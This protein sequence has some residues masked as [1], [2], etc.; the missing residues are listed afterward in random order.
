MSAATAAYE[1]HLQAARVASQRINKHLRLPAGAIAGVEFD[2]TISWSDV[3][4]ISQI[5]RD[6]STITDRLFRAAADD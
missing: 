1:S 3:E 4:L 5:R 2:S 6:L